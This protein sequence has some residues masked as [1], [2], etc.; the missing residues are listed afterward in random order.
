MHLFVRVCMRAFVRAC[1]CVCART[2]ISSFDKKINTNYYSI[3]EI[4]CYHQ[5]CIN[6]NNINIFL[7]KNTGN[8]LVVKYNE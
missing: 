7:D 2:R 6:N 3:N 5:I 4:Y 1:V 8:S